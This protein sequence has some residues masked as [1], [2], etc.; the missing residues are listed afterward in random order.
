MT[1][2]S[3][4]PAGGLLDTP[5][6]FWV[7]PGSRELVV[8]NAREEELL[9]LDGSTLARKSATPLAAGDNV[10]TV[11]K[12]TWMSNG[13][14][15]TS[16]LEPGAIAMPNFNTLMVSVGGSYFLQANGMDDVMFFAADDGRTVGT[17]PAGMNPAG[18]SDWSLD[19]AA[20]VRLT[21][22]GFVE[23]YRF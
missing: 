23:V 15:R 18:F 21:T 9:V 13:I 3:G 6:G 16:R 19:D 7:R 11:G 12:R 14:E 17:M 2:R 1:D 22:D 10:V 4:E 20:F 8:V 5:S